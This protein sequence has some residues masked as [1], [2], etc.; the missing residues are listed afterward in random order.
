MW[1]LRELLRLVEKVL[2]G[3][4][5]ALVAALIWAAVS[6]YSF[7]RNLHITTLVIGAMLLVM[8]AVGSGSN[9]DRSMDFGVTQAAWGRIPGVST[10]KRAGEDPTMRPGIVLVLTGVGLLAV[11]V[12][13]FPG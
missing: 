2:V 1:V 9:M 7:S 3:F 6:Q 10:T 5:V 8:G 11:G 4:A 13:V 12:F